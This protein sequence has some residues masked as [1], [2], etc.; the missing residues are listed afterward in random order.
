MTLKAK[1]SGNYESQCNSNR[2]T[3]HEVIIYALI[4]VGHRNRQRC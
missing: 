1:W 4:V 2:V 3:V